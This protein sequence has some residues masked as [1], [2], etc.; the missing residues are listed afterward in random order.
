VCR[1][2][3][4][5]SRDEENPLEGF[6]EEK[7]RRRVLSCIEPCRV[8]QRLKGRPFGGFEFE[9]TQEGKHFL[10]CRQKL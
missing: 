3:V 9:E 4:G 5:I 1:D 8:L 10:E 7:L 2:P 6:R